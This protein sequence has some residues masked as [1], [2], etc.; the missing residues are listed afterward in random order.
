MNMWLKQLGTRPAAEG[1]GGVGHLQYSD[2]KVAN[3]DIS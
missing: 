1:D 3:R 2:A